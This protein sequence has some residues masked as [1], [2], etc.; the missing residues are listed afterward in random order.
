MA[1]RYVSL[2]GDD[3][4]GTTW[5]KAYNTIQK[6]VDDFVATGGS[7][8]IGTGFYEEE[9]TILQTASAKSWYFYGIGNVRWSSTG[10][11]C[12]HAETVTTNRMYLYVYD[13]AFTG[14][15]GASRGIYRKGSTSEYL[16]NMGFYN[17]TFRDFSTYGIEVLVIDRA[18]GTVIDNCIF[19]NC[20]AGVYYKGYRSYND[21]VITKNTFIGCVSGLESPD[22]AF[23]YMVGDEQRGSNIAGNVFVSCVSAWHL[24]SLTSAN[25]TSDL[26]GVDVWDKN[27]YA[28]CDHIARFSDTDKDTLS[29]WQTLIQSANDRFEVN[30]AETVDSDQVVDAE[31]F[32]YYARHGKEC[33]SVGGIAVGA[34]PLGIGW[35]GN[36]NSDSWEDW[37]DDDDTV[38]ADG[39]S[40]RFDFTSD[41]YLLKAGQS[42][43]TLRSPVYDLGDTEDGAFGNYVARVA[44]GATDDMV[45]NDAISTNQAIGGDDYLQKTL[46]YRSSNTS[47][48]Q[49][50]ASPSW[51]E[52][53]I[54]DHNEA[55]IESS[56]RYL[57]IKLTFRDDWGA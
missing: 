9:V 57:Q 16:Y 20:A 43:S 36:V 7:I 44:L 34:R 27:V 11:S 8:Y 3:S 13:I 47:F 2:Q 18:Y 4:D 30:S 25:F 5:D 17:S 42:G 33:L 45:G 26:G 49:T 19:D 54:T 15:S 29:A 23:S 31:T 53:E 14:E 32:L 35:S 39:G 41:E 22:T 56:G 40:T 55:T 12:L 10:T 37:I 48:A 1:D 6:A 28:D 50:D 52:V 38:V 24:Q 46:E 51:T 21:F